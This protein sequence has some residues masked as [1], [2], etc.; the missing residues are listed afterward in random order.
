MPKATKLI[1]TAW[2]FSA[3]WNESFRAMPDYDLQPRARVWASE[4][5]GSYRDRYLKMY[6]HPYSNPINFRSRQKMMAGKFF[7]DVVG[8]VL[9]AT[10][11][12]QDRQLSGL[13][14]LDG[15]LPVSGKKDFI[16]GGVIDWDMAYDEAARLKQIFQSS[17]METSNFIVH[18]IDRILPHF[19]NLFSYNPAM[20][21]V[22]EAKS[23][24]GFVFNLIEKK[25]SPRRGHDLQAFHYLLSEKDIPKSLLLYIS[26]EDCMMHEFLIDRDKEILKRYVTDVKTMTAYYNAAGKNYLKNAP[27]PDPEVAFEEASC[28]FVKSNSVEY[29]PYLTFTYGIKSIDD[30]KAKWDSRLSKFNRV[31]KRAVMGENLTKANLEIIADAKTVFPDWDKYVDTAKANGIF[32]PEEESE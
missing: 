23:V 13:V 11:L 19:K 27:P 8:I 3:V 30:F 31:F 18:M 24:S 22:L 12:I 4:M 14:Q 16:A 5:G 26:R 21:Y 32:E 10:G 29:S 28:R 15:M 7:E 6:A 2:G 17:K 25:N 9:T 20:Q 1:G